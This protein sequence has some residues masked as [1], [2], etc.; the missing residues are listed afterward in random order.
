MQTRKSTILVSTINS[1]IVDLPAFSSLSH[2]WNIGSMLG[3]CLVI[4][5]ITGIFLAIHYTCDIW[6]A[7][8][9]I[10]HIIRDVNNGW[11]IRIFH[12]NGAS[13]FFICIFIH[14]GRG[15]YF[16]S[17]SAPFTWTIGVIIFLASMVTAFLGY[18]LPWGQMSYWGATVITNLLSAIPFIGHFLVEWVWG[19]FSVNNA[20]LTR[21][22][23]LHYLFPFIIRILVLLHLIFLH[24]EKSRN[25]LG[26]NIPSDKIP[27]HPYFTLK[28]LISVIL[29]LTLF[30]ILNFLGPFS[31]IDPENFRPA[32]PLRTP[33]HIQ[34]EWYFLFAYAI[35]RSIPN[36]LGGVLALI[37]SILIIIPLAL[38]KKHFQTRKLNASRKLIWR[39]IYCFLL[40]TWLGIIPVESP[41][42]EIRL[43]LTLFYFSF[44]I[45]IIL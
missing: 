28:D 3:V 29:I 1:I 32:N 22:F 43:I 40:L 42:P 6:I 2:F 18:V 10:S 13:L 5:I 26:I 25:P 33:P 27:F 45:I 21:F 39:F 41:F 14:I 23:S 8:E 19:G 30:S 44:F 38:K 9:S 15:L 37:I 20:T 24:E 7:F 31:L 11:F 34:P 17:F 12:A 16:S 35:L 36:K 4:Q